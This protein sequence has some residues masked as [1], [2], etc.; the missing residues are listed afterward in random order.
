MRLYRLQSEWRPN[1]LHSTAFM[2]FVN[3]LLGWSVFE[4]IHGSEKFLG[5][6]CGLNKVNQLALIGELYPG[7][8]NISGF[9]FSK[10]RP[11]A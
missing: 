4:V 9:N 5:P 6:A 11:R 7:M 1:N 2:N 8:W 10:P 3:L